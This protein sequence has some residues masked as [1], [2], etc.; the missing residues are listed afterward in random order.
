MRKSSNLQITFTKLTSTSKNINGDI[1]YN[2]HLGHMVVWIYAF[3]KCDAYV[4][5]CG[6]IPSSH[7]SIVNPMY[8]HSTKNVLTMKHRISY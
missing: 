4:V 6:S 8:S 5:K 3:T 1:K 2:L 7:A